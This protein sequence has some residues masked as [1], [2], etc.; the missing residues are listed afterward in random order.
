VDL[1]YTHLLHLKQ[2]KTND[3]N[4]TIV[5]LRAELSDLKLAVL[6]AKKDPIPLPGQPKQKPTWVPKEGQPL[7]VNQNG[8]TWK[9]CGKCHR[10]NQTNTTPEHKSKNDTTQGAQLLSGQGTSANL[11]PSGTPGSLAASTSASLLSVPSAPAP[12]PE[13][14]ANAEAYLHLDF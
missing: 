5:S 11:A 13:S 4:S 6:A 12:T 7:I 3:P 2:W 14:A 9:Y 10:W 8:K 1:E